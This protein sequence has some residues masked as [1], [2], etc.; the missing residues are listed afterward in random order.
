[1]NVGKEPNRALAAAMAQAR[2][3]N[4][5]V[6]KRVRELAIRDQDLGELFLF[7]SVSPPL[8]SPW[9]FFCTPIWEP[10]DGS[11]PVSL[12]EDVPQGYAETR[13]VVHEHVFRAAP[14]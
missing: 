3:S 2:A 6:A 12:L 7:T 1:M 10:L 13:P 8:V 4:H 14:S 5:G 11:R 9:A